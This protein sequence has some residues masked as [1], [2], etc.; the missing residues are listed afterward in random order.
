MAAY[1]LLPVD[2]ISPVI[3]AVGGIDYPDGLIPVVTPSASVDILTAQ[4]MV[5]AGSTS[6]DLEDG[7]IV[8]LLAGPF[9][10]TRTPSASLDAQYTRNEAVPA[11]PLI[12]YAMGC[13]TLTDVQNAQVPS[14]GAF[15]VSPSFVGAPGDA[16]YTDGAVSN[17]IGYLNLPELQRQLGFRSPRPFEVVF[18]YPEGEFYWYYQ[19]PGTSTYS[20]VKYQSLPQR[21]LGAMGAF[22]VFDPDGI[23]N[24]YGQ[25]LGGVYAQLTYDGQVLRGVRSPDLVPF[26]YIPLAAAN[27][28]AGPA[29]RIAT[30]EDP[31]RQE[32]VQRYTLA[33]AP[34]VNR[35]IGQ[36]LAVINRIRV[37]GYSGDVTETWEKI[38]APAVWLTATSPGSMGNVPIQASSRVGVWGMRD[39]VGTPVGMV[40]EVGAVPANGLVY[41]GAQ[42]IQAGDWV[43]IGDGAVFLTFDFVDVGAPPPVTSG[44][45]N[46]VVDLDGSVTIANLSTAIGLSSLAITATT[47]VP[48]PLRVE[49]PHGFYTGSPGPYWPTHRLTIYINEADGSPFTPDNLTRVAT[50]QA[51]KRSL[52]RDILPV[53]ARIPVFG[54]AAPSQTDQATVGGRLTITQDPGGTPV[55]VYDDYNSVPWLDDGPSP[56]STSSPV[57]WA[58]STAYVIDDYVVNS[59]LYFVCTRSGTSAPSGS[60]PSGVGM[61][62]SDGS[63]VWSY[64]GSPL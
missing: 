53:T 59:G 36:E 2:A 21:A 23:Y 34:S 31:G 64:S 16:F 50:Q 8:A 18:F 62:I 24:Y 48:G 9:L 33:A 5:E 37:L 13:S 60:G 35:V 63:V 56:P 29:D 43:R 27:I 52:Y 46:V 6:L 30:D 32:T 47:T 51:V 57:A 7:I 58:T 55:V 22:D 44:H 10:I 61:G 26:L 42:P 4:S 45:I 17:S 14:G 25:L 19:T 54:T 41:Q 49:Y 1:F 11:L 40:Y 28:G 20:W 38:S 39:G 3:L 12:V 15:L